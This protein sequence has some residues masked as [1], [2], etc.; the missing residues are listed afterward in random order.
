MK[1]L[2]KIISD[3][4]SA[5]KSNP[6]G[7]GTTMTGEKTNEIIIN[8]DVVLRSESLTYFN[9]L[10]L[11]EE[12]KEAS[13]TNN[14][15][16]LHEL[17]VHKHLVEKHGA[18]SHDYG[19]NRETPENAHE[20]IATKLYGENYQDHPKYQD[21]SKRAEGAADHVRKEEGERWK[22]NK[23]KVAWTSKSGDVEKLTG[24]IATQKGDASD[25]YIHH[26]HLKGQNEFVGY[27]LK[28]SKSKNV[29]PPVSNGGRADVDETLDTNTDKHITAA[30]ENMHKKYPELKGMSTENV[31]SILESNPEIAAAEKTERAKLLRN[32]AG[33]WS[34]S[35]LKMHPDHRASFLRT[36][37]RANPTGYRH[38]RLISGGTNGDF[39]HRSFDP[40][41]SHNEYLNDPKNI[42]SQL[43]DS[44][45]GIDFVHIH[46]ITKKVTP[47]LR[48]RTKSASSG[49][50]FDSIKTS[51]EHFKN[52]ATG[53]S[54]NTADNIQT[55][56]Q[57]EVL[58]A[59]K[60]VKKVT[61]TAPTKWAESVEHEQHHT[62]FWGRANPPTAGHEQAYKT[63]KD[64]MRKTGGTGSIVLSR[65]NDPKKN[66]LTPEQKEL[67]AQ[68]AFP[69]VNT[70]VADADHPTILHQLS[71]LH[72]NGVTHL[73]IVA[74][75]DRIPEYQRL[76]SQ[77][78]GKEG[79]HGYYNFKHVNFVSAGERD[80]DGEGTGGVSATKQRGYANQGDYESFAKGAPTSMKPEH[81]K[82]LYNDV[83]AGTTPP[84]KTKS[85][86]V[87]KVLRTV[88]K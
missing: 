8:P 33:N 74:G 10:I 75:S 68:R 25:L 58:P 12:K 60:T 57:P 67:H 79:G 23:T 84:K 30:R 44:G 52:K 27:S 18:V 32:I 4:I 36:A 63:V 71:K 20:R 29:D 19:D 85:N 42:H 80:P 15:G 69:D 6:L 28:K 3:K 45:S 39:D 50:I 86:V 62:L 51:G 7:S 2:F 22:E 41:T 76:I 11:S 14:E 21:A 16:V 5:A 35:F 53:K 66:P 82:E 56:A 55:T 9:F 87:S 72:E 13:A 40:T 46:P 38:V 49:G 59:V 77:Y 81:V 48:I 78:N 65:S 37:M 47:L 83:R 88:R 43:S 64:T 26:P 24:K 17:L 1:N 61:R 31:K 34:E 73:H 54:L 70:R